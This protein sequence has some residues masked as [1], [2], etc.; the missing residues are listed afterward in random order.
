M[1]STSNIIVLLGSVRSGTTVFRQFLATH[2]KLVNCGE[3]FSSV[4]PDG[5]YAFLSARCLTDKQAI[6]PENQAKA[7]NQYLTDCRSRCGRKIPV[8]DIK[9]QHLRL[10]HR[11]WE[12]P[13]G[14]PLLLELMKEKEL[15]VI[16]LRRNPVDA[17]ISTALA[18]HRNV[19]HIKTD[20]AAPEVNTP[21]IID[22]R[23]FLQQIRE[24]IKTTRF[25]SK[26]FLSY[27]NWLELDYE[28]L[29]DHSSGQADF[30]YLVSNKVAR[31]IGIQNNF[32]HRPKLQKLIG[33]P[34]DSLIANY[35]DLEK[36]VSRYDN[37]F[38]R[39]NLAPEALLGIPF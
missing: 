14:T 5:F 35:A 24:R 23:L 27:K 34:R 19:Y 10:L 22:P 18:S 38:A 8:I 25:I 26:F 21:L 6:M 15:F 28:E 16:H 13:F 12:L 2:P 4:R 20:C 32:D 31:S 1:D 29:F 17:V 36:T 7:F 37:Y 9:H 3:I 30:S 33:V 39:A 11:P